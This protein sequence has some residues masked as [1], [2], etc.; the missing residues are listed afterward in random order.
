MP[1]RTLKSTQYWLLKNSRG[2][3]ICE[4]G[5]LKQNSNKAL[6]FTKRKDALEYAKKNR[7]RAYFPVEVI[8][9][10]TIDSKNYPRT[11][12]TSEEVMIEHTEE[13]R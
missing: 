13:S 3:Y 6:H 12:V 8:L 10:H 1:V 9:I 2:Q 5:R 7:R 4:G 11:V